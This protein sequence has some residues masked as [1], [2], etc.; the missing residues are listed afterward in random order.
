M[1][2]FT[3]GLDTYIQQGTLTD[4]GHKRYDFQLMIF[5][6]S[7]RGK[8]KLL[9]NRINDMPY[10]RKLRQRDT[11]KLEAR[12]YPTRMKLSVQGN[13]FTL[14]GHAFQATTKGLGLLYLLSLV[15]IQHNHLERL[16]IPFE[17]TARRLWNVTIENLHYQACS[18]RYDSQETL[19]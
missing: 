18:R 7:S 9:I 12:L 4:R 19:F 11:N 1:S 8:C 3:A 13:G 16:S 14:T 15:G 6:R 5:L 2:L 10:S 17:D